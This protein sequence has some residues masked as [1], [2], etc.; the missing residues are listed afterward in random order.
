MDVLTL[1]LWEVIGTPTELI[2]SGDKHEVTVVYDA[3]GRL[4]SVNDV[5]VLVAVKDEPPPAEEPPKETA[6]AAPP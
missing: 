4:V 3:D 1:G 5:T 2:L 6:A